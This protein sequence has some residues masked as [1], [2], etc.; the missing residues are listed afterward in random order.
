MTVIRGSYS[1]T[2]NSLAIGNTEIGFRV[3]YSYK[4]RNINFDSVGDTPV[5]IIFAG[6][7]MNVDFVAQ[8]YDAAAIDTLRWPFDAIQGNLSPAGLSMWLLAKPLV[9]TGCTTGVDPQTITFYKTILSP[10]FN[11]DIDYSHRERPLPMRLIVFPVKYNSEGYA[12]PE[13]PSGCTDLVYYDE[14]N[15]P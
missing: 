11:L 2:Y 6:L 4:G 14:A 8:E 5:D 9:L 12:T 15:W 1:G 10:D 3:S 13:L 7:N